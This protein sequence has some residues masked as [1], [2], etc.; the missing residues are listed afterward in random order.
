M[1]LQRRLV[2]GCVTIAMVTT[3]FAV[4]GRLETKLQGAGAATTLPAGFTE[5]TLLSGLANP[6]NLAVAEDGRVFV[7]EKRGVVKI[8]RSFADPSPTEFDLRSQVH[9]YWDRGLLGIA[10][11]PHLADPNLATRRPYIYIL[12]TYD[13]AIGA[14]S[15]KWGTPTGDG[16]PCPGGND[17]ALEA[18]TASGRLSR[19]TV[20]DLGLGAG[21][22]AG[23][24]K[25]LVNAWCIQYQTHTVGS[26]AVGPDGMLYATGGDGA[27]FNSNAPDYGAFGNPKNP[28]GDPPGG[29]NAT[30]VPPTA[31]GG[32]L[33]AQS[34]RRPAG[35]PTTLNGTVIR[36]DPD[37]GLAPPDNPNVD[38][39]GADANKARIVAYGL[40][41]PYRMTFRPGTNELWVGDVGADSHEEINRIA[42][43]LGTPTPNF[44]WPCYEG[45]ARH[46]GFETAGLNLCTSLYSEGPSAVTAAYHSYA[47]GAPLTNP[48]NLT[49]GGL[50]R[51][52]SITG[53]AFY[54]SS[55][56]YPPQFDDALFFA[57]YS[58]KC[59]FAMRKGTNGLPD[60]TQIETF[61]TGAAP[62]SVQSIPSLG[63]DLVWI[64][65][66]AGTVHRLSY[67]SPASQ[68]PTAVMTTTPAHGS[69]GLPLNVS[70]SAEQSSDPTNQPLTTFAWDFGDG[71]S[72]TGLTVSHTYS[73]RGVYTARLSVTNATGRTGTTA[74]T[75]TVG[76]PGV[77]ITTP[78]P[79]LTYRAGDPVSFSG[80][81]TD[82]SGFAIPEANLTWRVTLHHCSTPTSCH[83][84]LDAY[85]ASGAASG[86]FIA[87]DHEYPSFLELTAT[88]TDGGGF[89]GV[90]S[91]TLQPQTAAITVTSN[92]PGLN[93]TAGSN[94]AIEPV[95]TTVVANSV[96]TISAPATQTIGATT[97]SFVGWSDG[98]APSHLVTASAPVNSFVATY[99]AS[100]PTVVPSPSPTHWQFNGSARS[101]GTSIQLTKAALR[102]TA[103]AFYRTPIASAGLRAS[104]DATISGGTGADGLTLTLANPGT[105]PTAIGALWRGS[106]LG[107]AGISG[108]AITLDTFKSWASLDPSA[109][110]IG[111]ADG[112]RDN[113]PDF[114]RYVATST[115]VPNLRAA[116][117]RVGVTYLDGR[118]RVAID[119]VTYVDH[120]IVLPPTVLIGFTAATGAQTDSHT[121]SNVEIATG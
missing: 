41:N 20:S 93:L 26:V 22:V 80:T 6:T 36:V 23:S 4:A 115:S 84:H 120:A 9:N 116:T 78:S 76:A 8:F 19:L 66:L 113:R 91:V 67:G 52:S 5:T 39:P 17:M 45:P 55:G 47:H 95:T 106:A 54:P 89:V 51:I 12:Y 37:T 72:A 7:T 104:F 99:R 119:G 31:E 98:G 65:L 103:S 59:I 14:V 38:V 71:T 34:F 24:E 100:S 43:P 97:Y 16:D 11:D 25:V 109:N 44:G 86:Q 107:Y 94:T 96:A 117:R 15:P 30:L 87:P 56:T 111:I 63:G 121:V 108:V 35:E 62:V 3:T 102:Q 85:S 13:A 57:D 10:V 40:R 48:C 81:A 101:S 82:S 28:C 112:F 73:T 114:L 2:I 68:P 50:L 58:R 110:F 90:A 18:C 83:A 70:F 60:P 74:R 32:S 69:G 77:V 105:P 33:R 118:L 29:V 75:I 1:S 21:I 92:P 27:G 46:A 88:A 42:N 61:A 49:V 64:D 79:T 53:I